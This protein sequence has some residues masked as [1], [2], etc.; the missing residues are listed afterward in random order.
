MDIEIGRHGS[1]DGMEE[2]AELSCA[3]APVARSNARPVAISR[4]VNSAVV[5]WRL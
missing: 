4:A 3:V 1:V 2:A 5:P